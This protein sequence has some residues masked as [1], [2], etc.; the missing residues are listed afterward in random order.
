MKAIMIGAG[1]SGAAYARRLAEQGRD[2]LLLE[3]R[4]PIEARNV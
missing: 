1:S 3:R 4:A 2:V